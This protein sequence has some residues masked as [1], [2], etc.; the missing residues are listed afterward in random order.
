VLER[1]SPSGAQYFVASVTMW[2]GHALV[3]PDRTE[4]A[5]GSAD[6]V[7]LLVIGQHREQR[8]SDLLTQP[9]FSVPFSSRSSSD[10]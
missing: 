1:D 8:A 4:P 2:A 9:L 6:R 5:A 3:S 7:V 10:D